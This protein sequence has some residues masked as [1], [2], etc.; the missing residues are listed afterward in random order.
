MWSRDWSFERRPARADLLRNV[1]GHPKKAC[2]VRVHLNGVLRVGKR[3]LL[4]WRSEEAISGEAPSFLRRE[5][6]TR[7]RAIGE[8]GIWLLWIRVVSR[9]KRASVARAGSRRDNRVVR[10]VVSKIRFFNPQAIQ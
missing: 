2:H 5:S 4:N 6:T 7:R 3:S 8:E 1:T 9:K 10:L